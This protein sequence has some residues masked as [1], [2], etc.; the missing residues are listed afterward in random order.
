VH[1]VQTDAE[2]DF[3]SAHARQGAGFGLRQRVS[4]RKSLKHSFPICACNNSPRCRTMPNF[5]Q[6]AAAVLEIVCG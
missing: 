5:S 3:P 4:R 1:V 6:Q 2:L